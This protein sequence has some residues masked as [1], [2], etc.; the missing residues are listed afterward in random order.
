[1]VCRSTAFVKLRLSSPILLFPTM[2]KGGRETKVSHH[3]EHFI[4]ILLFPTLKIEVGM[5]V[6]IFG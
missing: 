1:M 5:R 4:P 2:K 6:G 3:P